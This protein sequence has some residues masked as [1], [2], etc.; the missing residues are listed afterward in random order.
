MYSSYIVVNFEA[1][2]NYSFDSLLPQVLASSL[3]E[4]QL[5]WPLV[6]LCL[7]PL[8]RCTLATS[9]H[10]RYRCK[11]D[12]MHAGA[13]SKDF[14]AKSCLQ[15]IQH[16]GCSATARACSSTHVD[17]MLCCALPHSLCPGEAMTVR[18]QRASVSLNLCIRHL[19]SLN[20]CHQ[21]HQ[22]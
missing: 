12:T 11:F 15:C 3:L 14:A 2:S 18:S 6:F 7:S 20:L 5:V 8:T 21:S 10:V 4:W 19:P 22:A 17:N 16:A 1:G 13:V 9:A